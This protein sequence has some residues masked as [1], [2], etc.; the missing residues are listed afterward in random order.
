[1]TSTIEQNHIHVQINSHVIA[2]VSSV[3]NLSSLEQQVLF[4]LR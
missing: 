4:I 2:I 1:V 3:I